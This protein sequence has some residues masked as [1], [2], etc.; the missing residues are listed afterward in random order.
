LWKGK[1]NVIKKGTETSVSASEGVDLDINAYKTEW[2]FVLNDRNPGHSHYIQV[3]VNALKM[4]QIWK[5]NKRQNYIYEEMDEIW[6]L[7]DYYAVQGL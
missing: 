2:A 5:T 6:R 7:V 3:T 4:F 1:T